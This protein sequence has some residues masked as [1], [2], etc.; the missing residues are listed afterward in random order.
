MKTKI[1]H[2]IKF[3]F[4]RLVKTKAFLVGLLLAPIFMGVIMA[5]SMYLAQQSAD[6]TKED[7]T[8]GIQSPVAD[9]SL[10]IGIFYALFYVHFDVFD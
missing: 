3:E 2:V 9:S 10:R 8:I 6:P 1:K 5:V 7:I 4:I